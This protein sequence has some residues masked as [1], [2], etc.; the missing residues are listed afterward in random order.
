M[1]NQDINELEKEEKLRVFRNESTPIIM[2]LEG[3]FYVIGIIVFIR[4]LFHKTFWGNQTEGLIFSALLL[5]G[6]GIMSLI[7]KKKENKD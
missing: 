5:I 4:L 7:W 3:T 6:L 1:R 2:L